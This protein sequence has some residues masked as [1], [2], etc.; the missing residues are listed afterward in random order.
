MLDQR[1]RNQDISEGRGDE[2]DATKLSVQCYSARKGDLGNSRYI[3]QLL[4]PSIRIMFDD[5]S[6]DGQNKG[7]RKLVEAM[8]FVSGRCKD[9]DVPRQ[10]I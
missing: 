7:N 4:Y 2:C 8:S 9:D 6:V 10:M 5:I 3:T 1:C